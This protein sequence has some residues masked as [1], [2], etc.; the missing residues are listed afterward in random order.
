MGILAAIMARFT[1]LPGLLMAVPA[2]LSGIVRFFATPVGQIV[3][4][5]LIG[6]GM[7]IWGDLHRAR[8]DAAWYRAEVARTQQH[9]IERD[10]QA[11]AEAAKD[12]TARLAGLEKLSAELQQKVTSYETELAKAGGNV[13]RLDSRDIDRLRKL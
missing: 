5:G 13:C 9:Q 7:F 11:K 4:V 1:V 8:T 12:A 6:V 3:A 10:A 2:A